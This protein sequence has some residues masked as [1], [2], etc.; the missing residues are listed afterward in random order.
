LETNMTTRDIHHRAL[1]LLRAGAIAVTLA[2]ATQAGA[3]DD[4]KAKISAKDGAIQLSGRN[5]GGD[6]LF[7][8]TGT[9]AGATFANEATC[10]ASDK[11]NKCELGAAGSLARIT[12]PAACTLFVSDSAGAECEAFVRGCIPGIRPGGTDRGIAKGGLVVQC[13]I[14]A[15]DVEIFTQFNTVNGNAF[16]IS[17]GAVTSETCT[18]GVPFSLAGAVVV[19]TPENTEATFSDDYT[20]TIDVVGS[21]IRIRR[22]AATVTN[23]GRVHVLIF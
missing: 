2:L 9:G 20:A 17:D 22:A 15:G 14:L 21:S 16:S 8:L 23:S 12:P 19:A 7:S 3:I 1:S 5:V 18:I 11:A 10:V 13:D 6:L 4:C